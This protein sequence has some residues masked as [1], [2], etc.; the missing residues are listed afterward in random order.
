MVQVRRMTA[1]DLTAVVAVERASFALPWTARMLEEE[2]QRPLARPTV[3]VDEGAGVVGFLMGRCY[4]DAWHVLDLAVD[5]RFRGRGI[6][7]RLLDEFLAAAQAAGADVLL[8]VRESN[9]EA[10]AL[11]RSR[12]FTVAAVRR[13][14]YP[15]TGE[16]AL[17]MLWSPSRE[18]K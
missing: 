15:E 8:E 4:P 14:Y 12:G 17:V 13:G 1:V 5:P 6:G 18:N 11:Y 7:G 3:A 16:D 10:L 9:V 2:L